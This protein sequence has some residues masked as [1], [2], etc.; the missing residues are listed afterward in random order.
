MPFWE[1]MLLICIGNGVEF[2][3]STTGWKSPAGWL[4]HSSL[5]KLSSPLSSTDTRLYTWCR[6]LCSRDD[7][8]KSRGGQWHQILKKRDSNLQLGHLYLNSCSQV[9]YQLR[10]DRTLLTATCI[11]HSF[12]HS[13]GFFCIVTATTLLSS[14]ILWSCKNFHRPSFYSYVT[15]ILTDFPVTLVISWLITLTLVSY[16]AID[17]PSPCVE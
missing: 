7:L 11:M 17:Y 9:L 14:R 10:L 4:L 15:C 2:R 13:F 1:K 8:F 6:F 12:H 16:I 3:T 5:L